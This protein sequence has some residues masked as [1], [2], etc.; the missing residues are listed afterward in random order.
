MLYVPLMPSAKLTFE[1]VR[2]IGLSLPE[3][4]SSTIYGA[5][6]IKLRG[7][8]VAC[9]PSHRSAEPDSLAVRTSFEERDALLA[10][11][12]GTYYLPDHYVSHPIVLVR[13]SKIRLDQL[14]DLIK[15]AHRFVLQHESEKMSRRRSKIRRE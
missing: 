13:F 3:V 2:K 6:A 11:Q 8:L 9:V 10:E 15:T 5:P 12:P 4:E 7:R 1:Q 14:R